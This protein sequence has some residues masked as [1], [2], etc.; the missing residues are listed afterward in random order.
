MDF[1]SFVGH[2]AL[3][4]VHQAGDALTTAIVNFNPQAA[5]QAEID[6]LN[7]HCHALAAEIAIAEQ[8]DE[9]SHQKVLTLNQTLT[10]DKT[11][12]GMLGDQLL[13]A[14]TAGNAA[15]VAILTPKLETV[16]AQIETI[17]G[18]TGDGTASGTLF[19]AIQ[20]HARNE[21]RLHRLQTAHAGMVAQV[22][23]ANARLAKARD[24]LQDAKDEAATAAETQRQ[25]ERDAGL[26]RGVDANH[27][28]QT[29]MEQKIAQ[30]K[31]AARAATINA[32]SLRASTS[33]GAADIVAQTLAGAAP[34]PMSA[35]EKLAVLTG[36]KTA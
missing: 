6:D 18:P 5:S 30:L 35:L 2:L 26:M 9:V 1:G 17:G 31:A 16:M 10:D 29:A 24:D 22:T 36:R 3:A 27:I 32:D 15:N 12:A 14:T 21:D 13:A 20:M 7:D 19:D 25:A 34:A 23:T 11:A 33:G 8:T 28:A 4:N